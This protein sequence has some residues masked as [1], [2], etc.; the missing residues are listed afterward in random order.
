M[1]H[2][3]QVITVRNVSPTTIVVAAV[4]LL[5]M[6]AVT[7]CQPIT[8]PVS[9]MA[10]ME[11]SASSAQVVDVV[12]LHPFGETTEIAGSR[13]IL[14]RREGGID[15]VMDAVDLEPHGAYTLWWAVF[16]HPEHC[17]NADGCVGPD[18]ENPDVAA[19]VGYAIGAVADEEG[20]A[21]FVATLPTGD[22]SLMLDNGDNFTFQL[23]EPAPGLL[24]P[25][26]AEIHGVIRTHGAQM[27]DPLA[28]LT[29]YNADC[30]PECANVQAA[31]HRP[32]VADIVALHPFGETTEIAGSQSIL[33]RSE[34][35]IDIVMDAV[36]LEPHGAYTL[37]WAVFNHPEHCANADGCIGP[38]FEN[39]DV[40]AAVGYATG[41]VSDEN[42]HARFVAT[43]RTGDASFMLDNEDNFTFQL[44]EP[45][46]GLLDP[47]KAEVHAVIRT[48]G[49]VLDDPLAQLTTY[50]AD[51]NP[52]CANVQAAMHFAV[53]E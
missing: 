44:V 16:N 49:A 36:D 34:R 5:M 15:I 19:M 20:R 18:F 25:F 24:D 30:N 46:P 7:A 3:K 27:D 4:G 21:R 2:G 39:P 9:A 28:Q 47:F 45:A 40:A 32:V 48:H 51:C 13:S 12:P 38:D 29:T 37:W 52:E 8:V 33:T 10:T 1:L 35:G 53:R 50:N 22:A 26:K 42:G 43:L 6:L 31:M 23:I 14:T 41:T 17:A 11:R